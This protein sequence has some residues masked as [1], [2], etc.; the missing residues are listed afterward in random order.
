MIPDMSKEDAHRLKTLAEQLLAGPLA[1]G[2]TFAIELEND[3]DEWAVVLTNSHD[4]FRNKFLTA[5]AVAQFFTDECMLQSAICYHRYESKVD[6]EHV[7][8]QCPFCERIKHE[9]ELIN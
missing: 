4:Q 9:M 6:G 5:A 8:W 7:I 3:G 1:S 2:D